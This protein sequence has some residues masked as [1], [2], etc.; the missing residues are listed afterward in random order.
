[1]TRLVLLFQETQ[2]S[3]DQNQLNSHTKKDDPEWFTL[4]HF[5][6]TSL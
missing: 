6:N 5:Y 2:I 1:M 4:S 3:K